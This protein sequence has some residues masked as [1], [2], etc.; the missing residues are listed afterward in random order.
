VWVVKAVSRTSGSIL[1]TDE[2]LI[3]TKDEVLTS[4]DVHWQMIEWE[5]F[6][7]R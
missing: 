2:W 6:S 3:N 7:E 4:S 1:D 5:L